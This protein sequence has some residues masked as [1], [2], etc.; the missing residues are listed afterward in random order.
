MEKS[1][2]ISSSNLQAQFIIEI[3]K[4]EKVEEKIRLCLDFMKRLLSQGETP[5]FRAFWETRS[6]CLELFKEKLAPRVRTVYW[7]EFIALSEEIRRIKE[8]LDEQSAFAVEQ[9]EVAIEALKKD[10]AQIETLIAG[11]EPIV[12]PE[13][14]QSLKSNRGGYIESQ[15][16]LDLLGTL[17]GRLNS[18]RKELV[19][20]PMR[21]RHKNRIFEELSTLGDAIFPRR[22]EA[23]ATLSERFTWDI[24]AFQLDLSRTF[25]AKEEIKALQ[26]FA[27][28]ITVN[29]KT[30][31][32]VR[33][34]L[35]AFWDQLKEKE[36]ER[37]LLKAKL[38][39]EYKESFE[40]IVP[41][42]D[43]L[44]QQCSEEKVS[45]GEAHARAR[46]ILGEMRQLHLG[47]DEIKV[48]KKRLGSALE[49]LEKKRAIELAQEKE[50][51]KL[52]Q[53]QREKAQSA[54]LE[55]LI[56]LRDRAEALTLDAL[57][58]KWEVLVKEEK[59]ACPVGL[60]GGRIACQLDAVYDHIQEKQ[61]HALRDDP[62][63]EGIQQLH[64]LLDSRH[65]ARR[66]LKDSLES[67]RKTVGGSG[68]SLEQSLLYQEMIGEEKLRL[69]AIE[70]MIEELEEK[71][72][73]MEE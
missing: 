45:W 40:K 72:F 35:S 17:T 57:V 34:K 7:A 22:K 61:W 62:S 29:T 39:D 28:V 27:K 60:D 67:H 6:R 65:K 2:E 11:M 3:E 42:I 71:L 52:K 56:Q 23:I 12:V 58:E 46:E 31:S 1:L 25:D 69:D 10:I 54:L 48:L 33:E 38:R 15:R 9:I 18:L 70:T 32:L 5:Q 68:L 50:R 41:Q 14:A 16:E 63:E 73:D 44:K 26:S 8:I 47:R 4:A 66:K 13:Q 49:P 21:I 30:F 51:E 59:A 20:T 43:L 19:H 24:E 55:K 64:A 53:Q 37:H 36:K